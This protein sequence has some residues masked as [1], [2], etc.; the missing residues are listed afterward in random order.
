MLE[1]RS[2]ILK[3]PI[4]CDFKPILLNCKYFSSYYIQSLGI[5][6]QHLVIET[7]NESRNFQII[8]FIYDIVFVISVNCLI[9]LYGFELSCDQISLKFRQLVNAT[10]SSGVEVRKEGEITTVS[11]L[12]F[13]EKI[14]L[15]IPQC[16]CLLYCVH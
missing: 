14:Y 5:Y 12:V 7:T 13:F 16:L 2:E 4:E 6:D 10:N 9:T 11:S 8:H 15:I 1:K 3:R